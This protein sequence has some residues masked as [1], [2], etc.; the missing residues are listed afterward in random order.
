MVVTRRAPPVDILRRLAG[1][2]AAVLP[3]TLAGAGAPAAMQAVDDIGGD[4]AGFEHQARQRSGERA[5]FAIGTS[6]RKC[7]LCCVP[8][9]CG[10]Q[11]IRVFNCRITSGIVRPSARAWKVS[12]MRCFSTGS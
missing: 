6:Y 4:A 11:P 10:H 8:V 12:A 5:A 3:K 9:L 1:D 7:L 2:E